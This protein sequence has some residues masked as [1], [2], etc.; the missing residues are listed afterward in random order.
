MLDS[1]RNR[2][3]PVYPVDNFTMAWVS[4]NL[5]FCVRIFRKK[6][7]ASISSVFLTKTPVLA[8]ISTTLDDFML[9]SAD[10]RDIF[11]FESDLSANSIRAHLLMGHI[12]WHG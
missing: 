3:M 12:L 6:K 4:I 9:I 7:P 5:Y 10:N 2:D 1:F 8:E 11:F